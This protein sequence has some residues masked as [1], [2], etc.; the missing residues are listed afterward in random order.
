M[1][2]RTDLEEILKTN[3]KGIHFQRSDQT[4]EGVVNCLVEAYNRGVDDA[5]GEMSRPSH[6]IE[7][8]VVNTVLKLKIGD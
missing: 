2:T 3:L 1:T 6:Q 7:L 4:Y 8:G 5:V